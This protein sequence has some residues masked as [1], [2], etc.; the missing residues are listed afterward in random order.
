MAVHDLNNL[1]AKIIC[2]AE[3]ALDDAQEPPVRAELEVIMRLGADAGRLV[4]T[5][6]AV[7]GSPDLGLMGVPSSAVVRRR[8]PHPGRS[9]G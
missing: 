5:F 1:L 3:L 8:P 7:T 4:A 6:A 2:A 9:P